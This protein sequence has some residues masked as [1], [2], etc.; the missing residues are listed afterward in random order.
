MKS[1]KLLK[2]VT[3]ITT[4]S[5]VPLLQ[6][7]GEG[8]GSYGGGS[9]VQ[10]QLAELREQIAIL[11]RKNEIAEEEAERRK[12]T[13]PTFRIGDSGIRFESADKKY[14]IRLGGLLHVD[15]RWFIA[16]DQNA[17]ATSNDAF[18]LRRVRPSISGTFAERFSF[19]ITPEL[20]GSPSLLDAW[21]NINFVDEAQLKIGQWKSPVSLER[22]QSGNAII[23]VERGFPSGLAPNRD[24]GA[25][26]R[27]DVW[28]KSLNYEVG[29]WNGKF[30]G[31]SSG[32]NGFNTDVSDDKE[33]AGR[34]F[35]FPFKKTGWEYVEGLGVGVSGTYGDRN[36]AAPSGYVSP[37]QQ[38]IFTYATQVGG[39]LVADGE[40]YRI[41][42]QAYWYY[43]GWGLLGEYIIS[44]Q[45]LSTGAGATTR[46]DTFQNS[47][48]QV[49]ASYVWGADNSYNKIKVKKPFNFFE[50][51]WGAL[52]LATRYQQIR[53]DGD[54]FSRGYASAATS[55][56]GADSFGVAVNWY[57]NDNVKFVIDYNQTTYQ[58]GF[59]NV[60]PALNSTISQ[61]EHALFTRFQLAF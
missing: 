2:L 59:G 58:T 35:G 10:Q 16:D 23:F 28:D 29:I 30:D 52:Q 5:T 45:T 24:I 32:N 48:W 3:M 19:N 53:F 56:R 7:G 31:Q 15:S 18:L 41:S 49:Q 51:Q 61:D 37:G 57:L 43:G 33:F 13:N 36:N 46:T 40:A 44:S 22:L 25:A 60:K 21:L 8:S 14:Q 42:P 55:A 38:T 12:Q 11:E 9:S 39:T 47:A 1:V 4:L 6:A 20:A 17:A 54:A 34:I 27:G 50:G 26:V